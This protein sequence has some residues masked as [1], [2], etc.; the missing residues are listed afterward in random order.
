MQSGSRLG[1]G[2]Q[3][4][5]RTELSVEMKQ[6][7]FVHIVVVECIIIS[8]LLSRRSGACCVFTA[9]RDLHITPL[10]IYSKAASRT[11]LLTHTNKQHRVRQATEVF[12]HAPVASR[13]RP[14][15]AKYA[16]INP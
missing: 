4:R 16:V 2:E 14:T 7:R 5:R 15:A 12:E 10:T 9:F 1:V 13:M 8:F 11:Q 3:C 6:A